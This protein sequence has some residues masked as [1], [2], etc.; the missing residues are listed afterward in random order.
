MICSFYLINKKY[1]IVN[2][3]YKLLS[4]VTAIKRT[5]LKSFAA[6]IRLSVP[7]YFKQKSTSAVS[8]QNV[9]MSLISIAF[10]VGNAMNTNSNNDKGNMMCLM[11]IVAILR[12]NKSIWYFQTLYLYSRYLKA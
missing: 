8:L 2:E 11:N 12:R 1:I 5:S 4:N 9:Y 7:M 3:I 10:V 6:N